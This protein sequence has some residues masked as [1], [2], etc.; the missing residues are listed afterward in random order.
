[1]CHK[2]TVRLGC[3]HKSSTL[4]S[5]ASCRR[6]A[7]L[8][9]DEDKT[10]RLFSRYKKLTDCGN[11]TREDCYDEGRI[12]GSCYEKR[13]QEKRERREREQR[14]EVRRN[15]RNA[16]ILRDRV[17]QDR[18]ERERREQEKKKAMER[19]ARR[20]RE[21]MEEERRRQERRAYREEMARKRDEEERKREF[22]KRARAER[23]E[24]EAR[25]RRA[26]QER[27]ARERA[28]AEA[29]RKR[30]AERNAA[31]QREERRR[32]EEMER[33]ETEAREKKRREDAERARRTAASSSSRRPV[34]PP[35][36]LSERRF[37]NLN[38]EARRQ[39]GL[40]NTPTPPPR[41]VQRGSAAVPPLRFATRQTQIPVQRGPQRPVQVVSPIPSHF[42][43]AA[44][45]DRGSPVV[46]RSQPFYGPGP[47]RDLTDP[48]DDIV[49]IYQQRSPV[50]DVSQ[51]FN[52]GFRQAVNP[53]NPKT[54]RNPGR[55]IGLGIYVPGSENRSGLRRYFGRPTR[56][57]Q[58]VLDKARAKG[59]G[60]ESKIPFPP[61]LNVTFDATNK[62]DRSRRTEPGPSNSGSPSSSSSSSGESK[63]SG[64]PPPPEGW[65]R[66]RNYHPRSPV[67]R[68]VPQ[69]PNPTAAHHIRPNT[70]KQ[71]RPPTGTLSASF[72][73]V[74]AK[75]PPKTKT[76]RGKVS[77]TLNTLL[78]G[79]KTPSPLAAG[80]LDGVSSSRR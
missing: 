17:E 42:A 53:T 4:S 11:L 24:R 35:G 2:T 57:S 38:A 67:P 22:E 71:P 12:C 13:K 45:I 7:K 63:A 55:R 25:E 74:L 65:R 27:E 49:N 6:L 59:K 5:I 64:L 26:R 33:E 43:Q 32:R 14:E 18:R 79:R 62:P 36:R 76:R 39:Q 80:A 15:E 52:P 58:H 51:P 69:G 20:Q 44:F 68:P 19:A 21:E 50:V 47:S 78:A 16:E 54:N 28:Q 77:R 34:P 73:R 61:G 60:R 37:L 1:M 66:D 3:G 31:R 9:Q 46:D 48:V 72:K 30:T 70:D 10:I 40:R 56:P 23:A 29:E 41:P 8:Q 75:C